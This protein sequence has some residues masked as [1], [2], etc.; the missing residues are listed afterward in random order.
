[1][2][3]ILKRSRAESRTA[4]NDRAELRAVWNDSGAYPQMG[5]FYEIDL[6]DTEAYLL[7]NFAPIPAN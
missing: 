3:K 1:M 6:Q 2:T 5:E 7:A 4:V